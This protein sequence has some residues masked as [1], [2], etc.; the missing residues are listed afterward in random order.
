MR[1]SPSCVRGTLDADAD[2]E[3]PLDTFIS[4]DTVEDAL[5]GTAAP[6]PP[7]ALR[8]QLLAAEDT[9]QRGEEL[10]GVWLT[11]TD[12][13]EE[14]F[15]WISETHAQLGVRLRSAC[16]QVAR[17]HA[18][19]LR[20]R[21]DDAGALRAADPHEHRRAALRGGDGALYRIARVYKLDGETPKLGLLTGVQAVAARILERLEALPEGVTVDSLGE[22]FDVELR[23]RSL[24]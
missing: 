10:F 22:L 21:E 12:Y 1:P 19:G 7:E 16:G 17:G 24:S 2:G 3:H 20:R 11:A 14:E 6:A 23:E 15:T 13:G 4:P 5:F 9:G 18:E 8:R